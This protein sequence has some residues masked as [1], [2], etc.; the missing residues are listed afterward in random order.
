V[1]PVNGGTTRIGL[2]APRGIHA[3]TM[4]GLDIS[5]HRG[6]KLGRTNAPGNAQLGERGFEA[7]KKR[8]NRCWFGL[9]LRHEDDND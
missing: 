2:R 9:R 5:A 1:N 3:L 8:G 6:R 7:G 4:Q